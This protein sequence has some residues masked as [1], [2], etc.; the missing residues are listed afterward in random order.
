MIS[1]QNYYTQKYGE[2]K[3]IATSTDIITKTK[4]GYDFE[5]TNKYYS[6][7]QENFIVGIIDMNTNKN[8]DSSNDLFK[9][10]PPIK[11]DA[12]KKRGTGIYSLKGAV[13]STSKDR[14]YLLRMLN[15]LQKMVPN[16]KTKSTKKTSRVNICDEMKQYL[17]YLEKYSTSKDKN[18][19]T[20]MMIPADHPTIPFPYN[21]EDRIKYIL[22]Q[23]KDIVEREFDHKVLKG[24]NGQFDEFNMKKMPSFTIQISINKY[25]D[26]KLDKLKEIGFKKEGKNIVLDIE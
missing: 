22:N 8:A 26:S 14:D 24:N 15:K 13:C 18:K 1:V 17:L 23:V 12:S 9:I 16:T 19:N 25:I 2:D 4:K 20:Y 21:L 7:R 3:T 5:S 10:R 6:A 11:K